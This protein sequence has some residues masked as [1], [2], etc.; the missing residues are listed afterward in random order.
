VKNILYIVGL[1]CLLLLFGISNDGTLNDGKAMV[2]SEAVVKEKSSKADMQH[3]LEMISKDLKNS[4]GCVPRRIIQ[5]NN[6]IQNAGISTNFIRT[7]QEFRMKEANLQQKVSEYVTYCQTTNYSA[8]L[9]CMGYRV[10]ALR[11]III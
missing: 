3:Q 7:L 5:L 9:G 8:I 11:K 4:N 1:F 10:Y 6:T 2:A